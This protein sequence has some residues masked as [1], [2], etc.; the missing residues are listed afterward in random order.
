M[1]NVSG[2][3]KMAGPMVVSGLSAGDSVG[4]T[5]EPAGGSPRP[6]TPPVV[7]IALTG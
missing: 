7:V 2:S 5:V 1:I 3:G 4:L 6:T